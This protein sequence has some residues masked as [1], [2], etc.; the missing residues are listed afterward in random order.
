MELDALR[1]TLSGCWRALR[2]CCNGTRSSPRLVY[3]LLGESNMMCDE[4]LYINLGYW[5]RAKTLDEACRDLAEELGRTAELGPNDDVL[6][7]GCGFGD[8]DNYWMERFA[9]RRITA[10]NV[11]PLHI[12]VAHKR[13]SQG[14]RSDR[15]HFALADATH[16]SFPRACF[17]K[18]VAL[19]SAFH[20]CSREAFL[21][22]AF[23]VLRPGGVLAVADLVAKAPGNGLPAAGWLAR[24]FGTLAWQI[25]PG[26]LYGMPEYVNILR[27]RGYEDVEYRCISDLVFEPFTKFQRPRFDMAGARKKLHPLVRMAA[28][29][30]IDLGFLRGLDYVLVKARKPAENRLVDS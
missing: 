14:G 20:F 26:N 5:E 21:A 13:T 22:E 7:A 18:V 9:P 2:I 4:S 15:I 17:D 16:L 12:E 29:L 3:E 27:R 25:P 8:Q 19:E 23:R 6:D 30:Q 28:K 24:Q 1:S 11:T 10:I